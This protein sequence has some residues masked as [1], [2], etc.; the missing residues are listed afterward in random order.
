MWSWHLTFWSAWSTPDH[1][2]TQGNWGCCCFLF[3]L[4]FFWG[5]C[6]LL[7][8][9]L[10]L[11]PSPSSPSSSFLLESESQSHD[12]SSLQPPP[13]GFKQFFCLSLPSSW[14]YRRPLLCLA[15]FCIFSSVGVSSCW[16][17]WSQTP[18]IRS[19]VHLG[20][21]SAWITDV[22]HHT[23]PLIPILK[24]KRRQRKEEG[25]LSFN[26]VLPRTLHSHPA[27]LS[28]LCSIPCAF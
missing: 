4:F 24:T 8:P 22:S 26:M 9:T 7:L 25:W 23:Q 6:C 10:S 19:S 5:C 11:L 18:D 17:G 12:L 14:D 20:L 16:P 2:G 15:N 1:R 3:L 21:Q 27:I 28:S 13:A